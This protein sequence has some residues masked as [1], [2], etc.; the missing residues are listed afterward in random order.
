[1]TVILGIHT[2][3]GDVSAALLC[4]SEL[5]AAVDEERFRRGVGETEK[6]RVTNCNGW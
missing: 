3:Y 2:Y 6:G 1:V 5:V 4:A